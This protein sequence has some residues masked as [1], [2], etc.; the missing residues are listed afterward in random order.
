[1]KKNIVKVLL[2]LAVSV[3]VNDTYAQSKSTN[4]QQK[5]LTVKM[6]R[7]RTELNLSDQQQEQ[8]KAINR[9]YFEELATLKAD[10]GAKLSKYKRFKAAN[11]VRDQQVEKI[12]DDKQFKR[13][14][15]LQHEMRN[16]MKKNRKR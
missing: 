11:E 6:E 14:K 1:M 15:E 7:Y 3:L 9:T 16:E 2:V 5:E 8:M 10:E 4:E 12:L 13:Y